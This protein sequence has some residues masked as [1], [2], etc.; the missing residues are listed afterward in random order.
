MSPID[1]TDPAVEPAVAVI[2]GGVIGSGWVL[3]YLRMGLTV[4]AF[5]PIAAVR[6]RLPQTIESFWPLMED[7]GLRPGA[8]PDKLQVAT[9]IQE[10]VAHADAVQE[11]VPE[12]LAAKQELFET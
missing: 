6:E 5:D 8:S 2:G 1:L 10:A 4:R 3:H 11:A 9:T 12:V 7:M